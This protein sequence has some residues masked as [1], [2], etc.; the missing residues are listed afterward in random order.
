MSES[1]TY[2]STAPIQ[3]FIL[4]LLLLSVAGC[5]GGPWPDLADPLPDASTRDM[6]VVPLQAPAAEKRSGSTAPSLLALETDARAMRQ[7][8]DRAKAAPADRSVWIAAQ[9]ATSRLSEGLIR[10]QSIYPSD[11]PYA[12]QAGRAAY[13]NYQPQITAARAWLA[14]HQP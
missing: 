5:S 14:A 4:L 6:A 13:R 11:G 1:A 9:I 12:T 8:L 2:I 10:W 7:A 3:R